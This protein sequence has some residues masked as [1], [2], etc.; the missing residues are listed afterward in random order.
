[1]LSHP[2]LTALGSLRT[3][4]ASA[5]DVAVA[6]RVSVSGEQ[7]ASDLAMSFVAPRIVALGQVPCNGLDPARRVELLAS[8]DDCSPAEAWAAGR[9]HLQVGGLLR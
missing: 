7:M 1:M 4:L 9:G 8:V 2:P 6:I 5:A 3:A